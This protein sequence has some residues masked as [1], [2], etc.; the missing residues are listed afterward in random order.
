MLYG[1]CK[2]AFDKCIGRKDDDNEVEDC[3]DTTSSPSSVDT[4]RCV[5]EDVPSPS[6]SAIV[7]EGF[8]H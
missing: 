5:A 1:Q 4:P 7:E 6:S 2:R 8:K 3:E